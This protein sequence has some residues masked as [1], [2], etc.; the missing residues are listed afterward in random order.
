MG[1][2][3]GIPKSCSS[4]FDVLP[5]Y[6]FDYAKLPSPKVLK[7]VTDAAE[8]CSEAERLKKQFWT[9]SSPNRTCTSPN[10]TCT[11]GFP[12]PASKS[13]DFRMAGLTSGYSSSLDKHCDCTCCQTG[14]R[15]LSRCS[16]EQPG[17]VSPQISPRVCIFSFSSC[18]LTVGRDARDV[19]GVVFRITTVPLTTPDTPSALHPVAGPRVHKAV[20]RENLTVVFESTPQ[21]KQYPTGGIWYSHPAGGECAAGGHVRTL[22]HRL[23]APSSHALCPSPRHPHAA[24]RAFVEEHTPSGMPFNCRVLSNAL[25]VLSNALSVMPDCIAPGRRRIGL[26]LAGA[27]GHQ[28]HQRLVHVPDRRCR[29]GGDGRRMLRGLPAAP[30]H[31]VDLLAQ[32]L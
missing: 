29:A 15:R 20:G 13:P 21:A 32:V 24:R 17:P 31:D 28:G 11:M 12:D 26:H 30:E 16:L 2:A 4:A 19:I 25:S 22:W 23:C 6:G 5:G 9:Y 1:R 27:R 7:G 10:R 14:D 3:P 8:C 18:P